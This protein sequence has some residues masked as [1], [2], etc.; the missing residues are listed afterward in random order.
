MEDERPASAVLWT[1]QMRMAEGF[2]QKMLDAYVEF[3][4]AGN[5]AGTV[6]GAVDSHS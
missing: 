3:Q 5:V 4:N 6:I 1:D 2:R